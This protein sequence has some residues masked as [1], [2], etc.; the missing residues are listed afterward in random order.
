MDTQTSPQAQA[1]RQQ[2]R[3][4]LGKLANILDT[5]WQ[6]PGT[7]IR[8]GADALIGLVPVA[9]DVVGLGLG[10][11]MIW[12]ARSV[13]A[14]PRLQG[15]MLLNL[16]IEAVIGIVPFVGDAFDVLWQANQ[17]NR[18]VLIDWMDEQDRVDPPASKRGWLVWLAAGCALLAALLW[19]GSR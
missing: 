16:G 11:W 6:I 5:A 7:R 17:R 13:Q 15:K 14:P 10:L 8:L 1:K 4:R 19:A 2:L 3:E 12:Q 9:G 18:R